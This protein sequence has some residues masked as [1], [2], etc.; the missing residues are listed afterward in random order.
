MDLYYI[1]QIKSIPPKYYCKFSH[2][3]TTLYN[4]NIN[5]FLITNLLLNVN[6]LVLNKD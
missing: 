3:I 5:I 4:L 6:K 2:I 1:N